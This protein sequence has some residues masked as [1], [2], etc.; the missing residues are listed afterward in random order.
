[1]GMSPDNSNCLIT[2]GTGFI[3]SHL[4]EE[5]VR[6]KNRVT[7][8][9]T[10]LLPRSWFLLNGL[11]KKTNLLRVDVRDRHAISAIIKKLEP[12]YVFHFAARAI[13]E[14]VYQNPQEAL[15]TNIMGTVNIL[16]AARA[17]HNLRCVLVTSSDKA[18]GKKEGKYRESDAL[19]GDHPYE[20][21]KSAADLIA[22]S[23]YK[24]YGLP[25]TITRFGN[26]YGE[27]DLHFSRIIPGIM[28]ALVTDKTLAIRSNGKF[29]RDYV[30]VKD[31]V[32][33]C[34]RLAE[35]A[36]KTTGDAFNF[37]SHE[38]LSVIDLIKKVQKLLNKKIKYEILNCTQNE[39]PSQSLDFTKITRVI[40]WKPTW[41]LEKSISNI[42]EFYKKF[43]EMSSLQ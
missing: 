34:M 29:V 43:Y 18:Y 15:E 22:Y 27:G 20:V 30:Y 3:G 33:G 28:M 6:R 8:I 13:V 32:N 7:V 11:D 24:T 10:N 14:E 37:G 36:D 4:V 16:E 23:Y 9:D 39:I 19:K 26:V 5:L 25:V 1:M 35:E 40:S 41:S 31:I 42:F 2:G 17:C 21:S 38:T 12:L